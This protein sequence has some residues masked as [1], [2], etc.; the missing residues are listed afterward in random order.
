[1]GFV[2]RFWRP[3]IVD[4]AISSQREK[5]RNNLAADTHMNRADVIY[6]SVSGKDIVVRLGDLRKL[7]DESFRL[8]TKLVLAPKNGIKNREGAA[9]Q[10]SGI[11]GV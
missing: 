8:V 3:A 4:T 1:M 2:S 9:R 10:L 6:K 5:P 7:L 11:T